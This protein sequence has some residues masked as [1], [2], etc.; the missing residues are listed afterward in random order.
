MAKTI[1]AFCIIS[2][3]V[4]ALPVAGY[5][6]GGGNLFGTPVSTSA[7][8]ASHGRDIPASQLSATSFG[9]TASG[10]TGTI[11]NTNSVSGNQGLTTVIQNTGNNALFQT[12][13]VV[14][15]TLNH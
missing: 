10:S 6:A 2:M 13:T 15:I 1:T 11:S 9:N 5:A 3:A 14:N 4:F 8:A 7:L 12:S